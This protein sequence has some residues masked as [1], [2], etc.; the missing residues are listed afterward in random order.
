MTVDIR[1]FPILAI[2]E[3]SL[4]ILPFSVLFRLLV[5][6][7]VLIYYYACFFYLIH[8]CVMGLHEHTRRGRA[9]LSTSSA[10]FSSMPVT[11]AFLL[12]PHQTKS[13]SHPL[14]SPSEA[15]HKIL[16]SRG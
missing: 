7:D 15:S 10:R 4:F 11:P 14:A 16:C 9:L 6:L 13:M 1:V 2:L 5:L 3:I 8:T 12:S